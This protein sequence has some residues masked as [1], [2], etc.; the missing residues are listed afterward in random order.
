MDEQPQTNPEVTEPSPSSQVTTSTQVE[1]QPA[2]Q[3]VDVVD[4]MVD[5]PQVSPYADEEPEEP[6][7][8]WQASEYIHHHKGMAWYGG[9]GGGLLILIV[10]AALFHSWLS[11]GVFA[12]M[13]AAIAVYAHKPPRVLTYE[14]DSTS[15]SIEGKTFPY[16]NFRSFAVLSETEWHAIDLEPTARFSPRLT[17]LFSDADFDTIVSHLELHLPRVD[18]DPDLIERASRYLRF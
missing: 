10:V 1:L 8:T 13:G 6:A 7:Y 18:R 3:P 16:S 4:Q 2:D 11:I 15:V 9:L 5:Q 17:V 14:L 12:V